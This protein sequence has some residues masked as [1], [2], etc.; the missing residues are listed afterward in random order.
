VK[1]LISSLFVL[2]LIANSAIGQQREPVRC[3]I[4]F[5]NLRGEE[6]KLVKSVKFVPK[7]GEEELTNKRVELL[8]TGQFVFAS[9]FPTDES[10]ASA[11]GADSIKLGLA[12]SR[13]RGTNAFDL[14]NNA[15]AEGT[16]SNMDTLRVE[17]TA[18]VNHKLRLTRLE[19]WDPNLE[20]NK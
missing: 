14:P 13:K 15:V 2:L 17:R 3:V 10:M 1:S 7:M 20:K 5:Y 6:W 11:R 19:C 12:L 18:Y 16:L 8:G 9:V 4:T